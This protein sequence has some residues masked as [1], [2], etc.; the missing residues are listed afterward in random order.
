M[1]IHYHTY[2]TNPSPPVI[3]FSIDAVYPVISKID[4]CCDRAKKELSV[5]L[6]GN[7]YDFHVSITNVK[8]LH[9]VFN[10][11]PDGSEKEVFYSFTTMCPFC[12]KPV[13]VAMD[14]EKNEYLLRYNHSRE[15]MW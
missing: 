4:W 3:G 5:E 2:S 6:Y 10:E 9:A 13:Q 14:K 7:A 1:K 8:G 15:E 11:H 12:R